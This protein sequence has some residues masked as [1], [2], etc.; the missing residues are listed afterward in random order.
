METGGELL[1]MRE[2]KPTLVEEEISLSNRRGKK[3]RK[4]EKE[5]RDAPPK[6]CTECH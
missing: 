4:R 5:R 6:A 3:V 1:T 2:K